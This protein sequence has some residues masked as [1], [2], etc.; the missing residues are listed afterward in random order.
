MKIRNSQTAKIAQNSIAVEISTRWKLMIDMVPTVY[1]ARS[2]QQAAAALGGAPDDLDCGQGHSLASSFSSMSKRP[3]RT[4]H[5]VDEVSSDLPSQIA[6]QDARVADRMRSV[7]A[8]IAVMSG[9]GGVGKSLVS[10]ALATA[11][12]ADGARV[13]LLDADLNGPSTPRLLGISVRPTVERSDGFRPAV[14][15]VGVRTMSMAL[16]LPPDRAPSWK[17]SVDAGFVWRG[18]QERTAFREFLSD[19]SWGDLDYLLVDLPPGTQRL[20]EIHQLVPNLLGAIAVTLPSPASRDSVARSLDLAASRDMNILGIVENMGTVECTACSS[21]QPMYPGD[22]GRYLADAHGVPLLA[23]IPFDSS[24]AEAA[25]A[26]TIDFWM[27]GSSPAV[28]HL[29]ELAA[30]IAAIAAERVI[31]ADTGVSSSGTSELSSRQA[32]P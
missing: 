4:Y 2:E 16:L 14:S 13:G 26:G 7:G 29:R 20:A 12:A 27:R 15:R 5:E 6:H 17:D 18:T 11:L 28:L 1:T 25:A 9:K 21:Q 32:A 24:L 8:P 22:A 3:F 30:R 31:P 19:V 23:S 10:C